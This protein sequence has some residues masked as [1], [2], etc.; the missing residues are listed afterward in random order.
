MYMNK[1]LLYSYVYIIS[2]NVI[3]MVLWSTGHPQ[4]FILK[5]SLVKAL[6]WHQLE[7]MI[8]MN[9]YV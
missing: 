6:T 7:S 4:I 1:D 5:I 3:V 8:H 2:R 9:D